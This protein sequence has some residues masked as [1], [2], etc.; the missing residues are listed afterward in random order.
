MSYV[1][2]VG[3]LAI[4]LAASSAALATSAGPVPDEVSRAR[5]M[6]AE[7]KATAAPGAK[8]AKFRQALDLAMGALNGISDAEWDR[9]DHRRFLQE[10]GYSWIGKLSS[11]EQGAWLTAY[12][13]SASSPSARLMLAFADWKLGNKVTA[14]ARSSA[15]ISAAPDSVAA[16]FAMQLLLG[17]HYYR[18]DFRSFTR[19][20]NTYIRIA[21]NNRST[22]WA[23]CFFTWKSCADGKSP[24][25]LMI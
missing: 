12:A 23:L 14:L 10:I 22:A 9:A 5:T 17:I 2:L 11:E 13:S 18:N 16:E 21:P 7:A 15:V 20:L 6:A 8:R 3:P 25:G 24:R 19:S 4:G 1:K